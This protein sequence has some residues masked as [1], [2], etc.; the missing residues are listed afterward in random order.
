M[1]DDEKQ[2]QF[3]HWLV[4]MDDALERFLADVPDTIATKLDYTSTSLDVLESWLLGSYESVEAMLEPDQSARIDGA[5]RYVGETFRRELGGQWALR[6]GD[7]SKV[8]YGLPELTGF[9]MR[10]PL[11]PLTL[12]TAS[13][14]RRTGNYLRSVLDAYAKHVRS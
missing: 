8:F 12:V 13:A 7:P 1:N 6:L 3:Q 2:L 9:R 11:C 4:D 5:A 14:D 10:T